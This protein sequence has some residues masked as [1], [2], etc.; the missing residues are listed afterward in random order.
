MI[1][2]RHTK[3]NDENDFLPDMDDDLPPTDPHVVEA[4]D[5]MDEYEGAPIDV[6]ATIDLSRLSAL[7]DVE[8]Q[9]RAP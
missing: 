9:M 3:M 2:L 4:Q 1:Y 6:W 5:L 8:L 7:I